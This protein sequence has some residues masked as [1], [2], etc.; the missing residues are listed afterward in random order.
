MAGLNDLQQA[1]FQAAAIAVKRLDIVHP[2]DRG[3][4]GPFCQIRV[5]DHAPHCPGV[6]AWV[7]DGTVTY[8]GMSSE[9]PQVVHGQQ[10]GRAFNDYTYVPASKA[11]TQ[12]FSP[13]VRVN[14]KLNRALTGGQAVTWWWLATPSLADARQL[15]AELI[16]RWAPGWNRARPSVGIA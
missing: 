9:L 4:H 11:A 1:G 6:Y 10:L 5:N 14:G 3:N 12:A 16:A 15:E 2:L 13:R 8:I 7:V